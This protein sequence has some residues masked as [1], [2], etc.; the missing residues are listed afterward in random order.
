M[1]RQRV[2]GVDVTRGL[3]VLG[4]FTAH[5]GENG[6]DFWS[7]SGW[8]QA[9]DGRSS[10]GFALL[11]GLSAALLSGG[12]APRASLRRDRA[13]I[14][15][16]AVLIG[17]IGLVMVALGTPVA[18]ILPTYAILFA[19]VT[20]TLRWPKPALLVAAGAV[21]VLAPP[22]VQ[23]A[24]AAGLPEGSYL[25]HLV[26]GEY[27]PALVW[28]AYLLVGL[29]VGRS[30]LR[31]SVVRRRLAAIGAAC[32]AFGYGTAAV[33]MR[34]LED[35][36]LRALLT[37]EPHADTVTEV[38][39]NIG[40]VL[41]VLAGCLVLAE[42]APRLVAPVAATG[43]LALTAYCT[44]L[45]AIAILGNDVVWEARNGTLLAFVVVT[46]VLT[47][48]WHLTLGRGPLERALHAASTVAGDAAGPR[49][50]APASREPAV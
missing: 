8:M 30:D 32:V 28:I 9:A 14:L 10:A 19:A 26:V 50:P 35:P 37:A 44:H 46:L 4:M 40:V 42:L 2:V 29:A 13:R 17:L 18:V 34:T 3:A 22:V 23:A 11:A 39:G 27:Y 45:V 15:A 12:T 49:R 38:V 36:T 7:G 31:S 43:A 21:V 41:L 16:R 1:D 47:T 25:A 5:L 48:A 6:D 24:R 20:L 33:A